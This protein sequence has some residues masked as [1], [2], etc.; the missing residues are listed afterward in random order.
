MAI[1]HELKNFQYQLEQEAI[2]KSIIAMKNSK[3]YLEE[4]EELIEKLNSVLPSHD[5]TQ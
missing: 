5:E 3:E 1:E 2:I 4:S